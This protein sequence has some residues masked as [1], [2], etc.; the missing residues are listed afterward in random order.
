MELYEDL[1]SGVR[2]FVAQRQDATPFRQYQ[3]KD[4]PA[5]PEGQKGRIVMQ[6]ETAVELGHPD[7]ISTAF[8]L[9]SNQREIIHDGHVSLLGSELS[10]MDQPQLPFGKVLLLGVSDFT[11][12]NA[13]ERQRELDR[14]RFELELSGYML[15]AVSQYGREWSRV[16][17]QA[18]AQG[19]TLAALGGEWLRLYRSHPLV[20]AAE[21]LLVTSSSQD[22]S[23]LQQIGKQAERR[24]RAMDRI[25]AEYSL[26]CDSCEYNDV[27]NEVD[28]L[29]AMHAHRNGEADHG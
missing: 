27:C 28:A 29:R 15:R 7:S 18:L 25:A 12:D 23:A 6:S 1:I 11:T 26:D 19:G 4:L 21:I 3:E 24:T 22:V 5:W 10:E 13:F 17:K 14:L 9:W 16:S 20:K 2:D 8:L